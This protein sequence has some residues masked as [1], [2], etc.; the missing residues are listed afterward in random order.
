MKAT[1][2]IAIGT[3]VA[4]LSLFF[5]GCASRQDAQVPVFQA[6]KVITMNSQPNGTSIQ[7][8]AALEIDKTL[9]PK[10]FVVITR[11]RTSYDFNGIRFD[12]PEGRLRFSVGDIMANAVKEAAQ[13]KGLRFEQ[14]RKTR[15]DHCVTVVIC[16]VKPSVS[17][18]EP[19]M[20]VHASV[21]VAVILQDESGA[22]LGV[23][24]YSASAVCRHST[25]RN[26]VGGLIDLGTLNVTRKADMHLIYEA[27]LKTAIEDATAQI[28]RDVANPEWVEGKL[29]ADAGG[30]ALTAAIRGVDCFQ[31]ERFWRAYWYLKRSA[32]SDPS[33]Q[34]ALTYYA[35]CL[36]RLGHHTE[37]RVEFQNAIRIDPA[38]PDAEQARKWVAQLN[39]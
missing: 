14:E 12:V 4:L 6:R 2:N 38:S 29:V 15:R 25:L 21:T 26:L 35:A 24:T 20:E 8:N 9:R 39:R 33:N 36:A 1:R 28:A 10:Q 34:A 37:A 23:E 22:S 5:L 7:A 11:P 3:V 13:K 16:G 31:Q 27:A 19:P 30:T 18:R 17:F 32:A